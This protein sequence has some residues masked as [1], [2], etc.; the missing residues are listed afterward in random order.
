MDRV[1][2]DRHWK[3]D[4]LQANAAQRVHIVQNYSWRDGSC[5][6]SACGGSTRPTLRALHAFQFPRN[7]LIWYSASPMA[8]VEMTHFHQGIAAGGGGSRVFP[9]GSRLGRDKAAFECRNPLMMSTWG[10]ALFLICKSQI[11][12]LTF[13]NFFDH[14]AEDSQPGT[15][16]QRNA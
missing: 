6:R 1:L 12:T 16:R 9:H 10:F 15:I 4:L 11:K 3:H 5:N 14:P 13:G 8:T 7:A 2:K